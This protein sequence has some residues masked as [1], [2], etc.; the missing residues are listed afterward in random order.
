MAKISEKG[1]FIVKSQDYCKHLN[2]A[3]TTNFCIEK[4]KINTETE[5]KSNKE[6]NEKLSY[7]KTNVYT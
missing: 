3:F 7:E 4:C 6:L 5:I 2:K 1:F